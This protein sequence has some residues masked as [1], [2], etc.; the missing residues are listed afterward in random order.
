MFLL[1]EVFF[2]KMIRKI[3]FIKH[4]VKLVAIAKNE[5]AYLAEWIHHHL[6]FKFD[7]IDIYINNTDDDTMELAL[8]LSKLKT[9]RFLD[10]DKYFKSNIDAPQI[11][12]YKKAFS[13][14]RRLLYSHVVF[15]DIDE[16]WC[17]T[18]FN[19]T[20]KD[21]L[22]ETHADVVAYEWVN[23]I[24]DR[25][26]FERPFQPYIVGKRALQVKVV[27]ST[28]VIIKDMNPHNI[29]RGDYAYLLADGRKFEKACNNF[30]RVD[31]QELSKPIKKYY[32]LHRI[33]RSQK[34]YVASLSRGRPLSFKK[35]TSSF[36][37]NR[38]GFGKGIENAY[39]TIDSIKLSIYE[40]DLVKFISRYNLESVIISCQHFICETFAATLINIRKANKEEWDVLE[41]VLVGIDLEEVLDSYTTF[42]E[43]WSQ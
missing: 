41:K 5:G 19:S 12:I 16:F 8:K 21:S 13:K 14:A 26:M 10:G 3:F 2:F 18:D 20:I 36:K 43:R 34:E 42:K 6:Y 23:K 11:T 33:N 39:I 25:K 31:K 29:T 37:S 32:I 15:L 9:V 17:S 24:E 38:N 35:T 4:R 28:D 1:G 7:S 40:E 27:V 22:S 30:S